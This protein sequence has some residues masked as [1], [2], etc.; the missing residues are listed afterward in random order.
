MGCGAVWWDGAG[1]RISG[2]R[3]EEAGL[4]GAVGWDAPWLAGWMRMHCRMVGWSRRWGWLHW[5]MLQ[6][7][8]EVWGV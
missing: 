2:G 4:S 7:A 5:E 1:C 3:K 6:G 8:Q